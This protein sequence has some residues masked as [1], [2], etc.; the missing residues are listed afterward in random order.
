MAVAA[1]VTVAYIVYVSKTVSGDGVAAVLVAPYNQKAM[2]HH[3]VVSVV[4]F[5]CVCVCVCVCVFT[6][7]AT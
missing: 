1:A 7:A 3:E 4:L 5:C 2:C 6:T